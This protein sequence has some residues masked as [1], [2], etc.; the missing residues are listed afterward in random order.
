MIPTTDIAI[1]ARGITKVFGTGEARVEALRG[2][3]LDVPTGQFVAVMGS[4]GSGKSTLL[5]LLGGLDLPTSGSV[6]IEGRDLESL[7][8]D[9]LTLLRRRRIGFDFQA[10]Q[11]SRCPLGRGKCCSSARH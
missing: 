5:H 4:S 2:V 3:D 11:S 7:N 1:R 6:S 9:E 8:D 10:L